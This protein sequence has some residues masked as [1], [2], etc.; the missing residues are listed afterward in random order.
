MKLVTVAT[1]D[2]AYFQALM[3]SCQR[4]G[5]NISVLGWGQPWKGFSMKI[6]L[7]IEYLS[8]CDP[9]EVI[10]FVDAYD[11]IVL[12]PLD[13]LERQYRDHLEKG[14]AGIV[15]SR[16]ERGWYDWILT[17]C[18][19]KCNGYLL[20]SGTYIG[21]AGAILSMVKG[22]CTSGACKDKDADDQRL[23]TNYCKENPGLIDV[24]ADFQWFLVWGFLD[25][26][27]GSKVSIGRDRELIYD[28]EKR[29]FLL[30]RPGNADMSDVLKRLGYEGDWKGTARGIAYY[31]KV[32]L[33]HVKHL[34]SRNLASIIFIVVL[35]FLLRSRMS[36]RI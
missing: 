15:I 35:L 3:E 14:G 18:F 28:Q 33:H 10:C 22:I 21:R 7:L 17:L 9:D 2:T 6:A 36:R 27:V 16:E 11:V 8:E 1:H 29:P 30:H 13:D 26:K 4:H 34:M 12:R 32:I 31:P 23:I 24:D 19:D 20:N 25:D 5:V